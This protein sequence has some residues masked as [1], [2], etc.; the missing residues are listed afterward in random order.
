MST[1]DIFDVE[2]GSC[3]LFTADNGNLMMIDCGRN[4]QTGWSPA[5]HL[6]EI[7]ANQLELLV[8][9]NYDEDHVDGLPELRE[10]MPVRTLLRTKNLE[11]SQIIELKSKN[12]MGPGIEELTRMASEYCQPG[13]DWD[14]GNLQYQMYHNDFGQFHD[15]NNLSA[16]FVV[17]IEGQK[18]L[19]TGDMEA[20][21]F[22][23]ILTRQPV[24]EAVLDASVLIAPHHGRASSVHAD[25]LNLV[26]PYWTVI[27]DKG[28]MYDTQQTV[29][30]YRSYSRGAELRVRN[31][32]YLLP[33]KTGP[34]G[35]G[36]KR[37]LGAHHNR[38]TRLL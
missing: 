4:V 29:P 16:L 2:H 14:F 5:R 20:S 17:N 24:K 11:P 1:L 37:A 33:A 26:R 3:A 22:D 10:T 8:I 9:T 30:A 23:T 7:G 36:L 18:V 31:D 12:G 32:Q 15:E 25:F 19:F 38:F 27:S 28:Y 34:F 35:F 13:T 6:A 21:G